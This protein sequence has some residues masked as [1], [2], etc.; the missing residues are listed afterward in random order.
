MAVMAGDIAVEFTQTPSHLRRQP[1][2]SPLVRSMR[3]CHVNFCRTTREATC[4]HVV[5][6]TQPVERMSPAARC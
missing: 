3:H 6:I 4:G 2:N 5:S 1:R